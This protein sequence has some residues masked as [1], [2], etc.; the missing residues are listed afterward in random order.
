MPS[1]GWHLL[2]SEARLLPLG[3]RDVAHG[4]VRGKLAQSGERVVCIL[5]F[6]EDEG[7][8]DY[9]AA[10]NGGVKNIEVKVCEYDSE[11][12]AELT[13]RINTSSRSVI[14]TYEGVYELTVKESEYN[15]PITLKMEVSPAEDGM[16]HKISVVFDEDN[17]YYYGM[18]SLEVNALVY[19][20]EAVEA[21]AGV[22]STDITDYSDMQF[23]MLLFKLSNGLEDVL[24]DIFG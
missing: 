24:G 19:E 15:D 23:Y 2:L 1:V 14:G 9:N 3:R 11:P 6:V 10:E 12:M 21:P 8:V 20:G 17:A 5:L 13:A 22:K 7:Y 4:H 16:Q 18:D